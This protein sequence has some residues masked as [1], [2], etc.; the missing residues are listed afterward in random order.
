MGTDAN[1]SNFEVKN[2][3]LCGMAL[4]RVPKHAATV[5]AFKFESTQ[6]NLSEKIKIGNLKMTYIQQ[7]ESLHPQNLALYM[8]LTTP[9][10]STD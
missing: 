9:Y 6:T 3:Q 5:V 7:S 1:S 10:A 4:T 2:K 8:M